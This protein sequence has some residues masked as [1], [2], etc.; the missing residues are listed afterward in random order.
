MG[1]GPKSSVCPSK[2]GKPNFFGGISRDFAGNTPE[3]PE[4]FE[5]K[6]FVF[7]FCSLTFELSE[8]F[9]GF[10]RAGTFQV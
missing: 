2:P 4:K 6:R 9:L 10:G 3:V 8:F 5:K 1:W 7:N